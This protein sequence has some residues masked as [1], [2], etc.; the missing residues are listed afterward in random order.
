MH[1]ASSSIHGHR[2]HHRRMRMDAE[3]IALDDENTL[4]KDA[5]SLVSFSF[6]FN[7]FQ[8]IAQSMAF[9]YLYYFN[10]LKK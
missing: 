3:I 5:S 2:H 7:D 9:I 10:Y 1:C 4:I 8:S 6:I